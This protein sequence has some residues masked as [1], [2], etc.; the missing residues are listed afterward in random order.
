MVLNNTVQTTITFDD[1]R[2][3]IEEMSALSKEQTDEIVSKIDE[4]ETIIA[5]QN[6]RKSKWEKIKPIVTWA[7]EKGVDVGITILKLVAQKI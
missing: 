4:L 3:H 2:H 6:G 1:A 7:V 5:E